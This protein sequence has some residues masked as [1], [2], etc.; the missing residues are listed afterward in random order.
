MLAAWIR[1][2]T[3]DFPA[4]NRVAAKW[5]GI[6]TGAFQ[7]GGYRGEDYQ[8]A[9]REAFGE[10]PRGGRL[11]DFV[12]FYQVSLVAGCLD[13]ETESRV[14]D[15]MLE[16]PEGI[17]YVYNDRV[18][19]LPEAFQSRNASR[20]LG[21]VELLSAYR[22][23]RRKLRFVVD[24]LNAAKN[25]RGRWDMGSGVRDLIYFPL[26]DSWRAKDARESDCTE[27]VSKL[28]G[29]LTAREPPR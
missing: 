20:Y 16:H 7:S 28:I 1:K 12:S 9:Y 13:A 21:A 26:S 23:S 3:E 22:R 10:K 19:K 4:A 18:S 14:F 5:A 29:V 8:T 2:F 17:F 25:E 6:L 11:E 24:W 15:Y 27:R